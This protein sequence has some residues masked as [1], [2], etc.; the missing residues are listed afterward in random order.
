MSPDPII[1]TQH[2]IRKGITPK[3]SGPLIVNIRNNK[4]IET[5]STV[6]GKYAPNTAVSIAVIM[7]FNL[8]LNRNFKKRCKILLPKK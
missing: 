3:A 6:S 7:M 1:P 4:E 2:R 8:F 5:A